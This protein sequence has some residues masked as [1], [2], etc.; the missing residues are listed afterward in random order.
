MGGSV[1][2]PNLKTPVS[3]GTFWLD[4]QVSLDTSFKSN[5]VRTVSRT[6]VK[7]NI[8]LRQVKTQAI[9]NQKRKVFYIFILFMYTHMQIS[10]ICF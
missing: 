4:K 1:T 9:Q 2:F 3:Q 5:A 7:V 6:F 8:L 10:F